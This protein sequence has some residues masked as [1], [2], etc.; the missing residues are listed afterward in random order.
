MSIMCRHLPDLVLPD[1]RSG[2]QTNFVRLAEFLADLIQGSNVSQAILCQTYGLPQMKK[3]PDLPKFCLVC[4]ADP[5]V[6]DNTGVICW[7]CHA[8][9]Q[10]CLLAHLSEKYC[11]RVKTQ[12]LQKVIFCKVIENII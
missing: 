12:K 7:F 8:T 3:L 2:R 4:L 5:A 1:N 9:P 10:L 6:N 11:L